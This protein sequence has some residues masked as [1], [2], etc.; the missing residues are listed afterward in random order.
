MNVSCVSIP[1][2]EWGYGIWRKEH[3]STA[4]PPVKG[5]EN[6]REATS[7]KSVTHAFWSIL[8][9]LSGFMVMVNVDNM[10]QGHPQPGPH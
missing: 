8:K 7:V 10:V 2:L 9:T 4:G 5:W 6:N 1:V 3:C